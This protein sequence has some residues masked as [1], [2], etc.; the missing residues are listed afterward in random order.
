MW[1]APLRQLLLLAVLCHIS[2]TADEHSWSCPQLDWALEADQRSAVD[3]LAC[4]ISRPTTNSQSREALASQAYYALLAWPNSTTTT[5][6]R[7][8]FQRLASEAPPGVIQSER[9]RLQQAESGWAS[10]DWKHAAQ[11]DVLRRF[12]C[13]IPNIVHFIKTDGEPTRFYL[14]HLLA[15][16][17]AHLRIEPDVIYFWGIVR[18]SGPWWEQAAPLVLSEWHS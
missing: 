16:K 3:Q 12:S 9:Q 18:P 2:S 5:Y 8:I 10:D 6:Y 7:H 13:D 1:H 15:I 11:A 14:V 4:E 17:A